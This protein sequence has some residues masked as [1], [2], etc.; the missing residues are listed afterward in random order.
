MNTWAMLAVALSAA[1][2]LGA[3][4][5]PAGEAAAPPPGPPERIDLALRNVLWQTLPDA[6]QAVSVGP[7]Q[8]L[9]CQ[10]RYAGPEDLAAIRQRIERE[11]G[12]KNPQISGASPVLFQSSGRVWFQTADRKRILGYDGHTWAEQAAAAY[13]NF[14]ASCP[15]HGRGTNCSYAAEVDG[16]A[17]F[18]AAAG[19]HVYDGK[20]WTYQAMG[21]PS[22]AD[23]YI[24]L[25]PLADGKTLLAP[26]PLR[27]LWQW[28]GGKWLQIKS[29]AMVPDK[30]LE[31]AAPWPGGGLWV[32]E[33]EVP[34]PMSKGGPPP[35]KNLRFCSLGGEAEGNLAA[36]IARLGDKDFKVREATTDRMLLLG[37]E[38]IE[39][40]EKALKATADPEVRARLARV[41]EVLKGG[42]QPPVVF[43]PYRLKQAGLL[44]VTVP[45]LVFVTAADIQEGDKPLGAA[46]WWRPTMRAPSA[47][48]SARIWSRPS[49]PA[50]APLPTCW[51]RGRARPS[52]S[53]ASATA[54]HPACWT[55]R[56]ASSSMRC[57]SRHS[58]GS[59]PCRSTAG[60]SWA[61]ACR[62][63]TAARWAC[64]PPGRPTTGGSSTPTSWSSTRGRQGPA[65]R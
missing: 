8:R 39:P 18:A 48:S 16:C 41:L 4:R 61:A 5:C 29:P 47:H 15:N 49:R 53:A 20:Q 9:W 57:P 30:L 42:P 65:G 25:I 3:A 33:S 38:A 19:V 45:G 43:G 14:Q 32:Q 64:T 27:G 23:R 1:A 13:N 36:L 50:W 12:E 21:A 56:R 26:A 54:G 31:N 10:L 58:T 22:N 44:N 2:V 17:F 11:F 59:T 63:P 46:W 62:G 55:W 34:Q 52:G 40:A 24:R 6:V 35:I 37:T 7:D 60:S 28:R 51:W